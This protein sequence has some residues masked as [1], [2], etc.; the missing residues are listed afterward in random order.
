MLIVLF[1][2][3]LLMIII[4]HVIGVKGDEKYSEILSF[5]GYGGEILG[6]AA[7]VF[8]VIA[9]IILAFCISNLK[10]ADSKISMYE[11][12]NNKIQESISS[13]VEN[14]KDYEKNTYTESLKNIDIKNTD[15]V[16]LTQLYPDLKA[17]GMVN[18]QI[19]IYNENN[20]KI[21]ELKEE[22]L[23]NQVAKW[24]LYFGTIEDK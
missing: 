12:E 8:V 6:C 16:V 13:I 22:K 3:F 14:Y 18:K 23:D 7:E 1:I 21:K 19:E 4:G 17:D 10:V 11:E 9:I 5:V 2:I 24:W 15:V 20:N